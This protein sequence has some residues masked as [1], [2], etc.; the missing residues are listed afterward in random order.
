MILALLILLLL[1]SWATAQVVYLSP[2]TGDG[3]EA[4]PFI[5]AGVRQGGLCTSLR[6]DPTKVGGYALCSAPSLPVADGV[7]DLSGKRPIAKADR[8]KILAERGISVTAT[9]FDGLLSELV[10]SQDVRLNRVDGRQR[11][12]LKGQEVWSRPAPLASY[13]PRLRDILSAPIRFVD[14]LIT[15]TIAWAASLTEDWNCADHASSLNCDHAWATFQGIVLA[16]VSN[17]ADVTNSVLVQL[18]RNT[19]TLDTDHMRVG[20]TIANIARGTATDVSGGV[21]ARKDSSGTSTY[22]YAVVRDAATDQVETGDVVS[23]TRTV[24]GSLDTTVA[25]GDLI[26]LQVVNDVVSVFLNGTLVQGPYTNTV[27][28]GNMLAG[29]RFAGTGTA[30]TTNVAL[31]NWFAYDVSAGGPTKRRH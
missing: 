12:I 7:I 31:D 5:A 14:G 25:N 24:Q 10:D 13:L 29:I 6:A 8:D 28:D 22:L 26:E 16:L 17:R 18:A 23:G 3:S 15:P 27:G 30:T 9:T 2:Y 1:P 4:N 11:I 21:L 20:V 19:T